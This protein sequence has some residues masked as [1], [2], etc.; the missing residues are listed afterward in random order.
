MLRVPLCTPFILMDQLVTLLP[1][2]LIIDK[3]PYVTMGSGSM[4]AMAIF[5][6]H[7]KPGMDV[8]FTHFFTYLISD[9]KQSI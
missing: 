6:A 4:A 8:C 5:E 9:K 1:F 7:Y 2:C 3:L